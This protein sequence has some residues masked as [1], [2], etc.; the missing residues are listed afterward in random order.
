MA[1]R[2]LR[3]DLGVNDGMRHG[4]TSSCC[5]RSTGPAF[6]VIVMGGGEVHDVPSITTSSGCSRT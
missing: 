6:L 2:V 5:Y 4:W 1:V 3:A